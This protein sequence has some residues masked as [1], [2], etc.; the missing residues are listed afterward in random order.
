DGSPHA[1]LDTDLVPEQLALL[2]HPGH[3]VGRPVAGDPP[4][5]EGLAPAARMERGPREPRP[6]MGA[7]RH[8][9]VEL[10]GVRVL[11]I[12]PL[13]HGRR[14]RAPASPLLTRGST[15]RLRRPHPIE[16][17]SVSRSQRPRLSAMGTSWL[18]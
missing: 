2:A 15:P 8:Q 18:F 1:E 12:E 16:F 6:S 4:L 13:S 17:T 10:V 3:R 11:E 14:P 5:I 7:L 9:R